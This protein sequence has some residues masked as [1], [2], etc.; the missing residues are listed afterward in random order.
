MNNTRQAKLSLI[1][2][3]MIFGTIG[4]FRRHIPLSSPLLAMLRG[5]IGTVFLLVLVR[6]KHQPLDRAAIRKNAPK[7]CLTGACIGIN[8]ILLFESY[9]YTSVATA[10]LCYYMA[11][12]LVILASPVVFRERLTLKKCLC[13][14]VAFAG[15]IFV[16]GVADSGFGGIAEMK[17]VFLALGAAVIYATVMMMNKRLQGIAA[18][19]RTI[20]QLA[21]A[22]IVIFPYVL[23][24]E[25]WSAV[26]IS[27]LI[28]TLVLVVGMVHTGF[29]YALY[30]GAISR[31]PAQTIALF[32]YIDPIVAIFLSAT[33]LREGLTLT[34][35]IGAVLVLGSTL[36]SEL[37][38]S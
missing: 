13:A 1:T 30:F 7:L 33:L 19:D 3:M 9:R 4:I 21:S 29:T 26:E 14:A 15:M 28:V 32:S 11:P 25:D 24:T 22:A 6:L 17:G 2:A 38:D 23:L 37:T 36:V 20:L 27:P 34:S 12:I 16:S 8:W 18:Y 31:L 10:T 5:A 35:A